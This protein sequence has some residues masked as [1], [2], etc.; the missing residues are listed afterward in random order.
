LGDGRREVNRFHSGNG[1]VMGI[2]HLRGIGSD[3]RS[4]TLGAGAHPALEAFAFTVEPC[5]EARYTA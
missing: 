1:I 2:R 3:E 5:K 4:V